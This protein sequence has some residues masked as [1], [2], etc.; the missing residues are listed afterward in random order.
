MEE[1][2]LVRFYNVISKALKIK[3]E[4]LISAIILNSESIFRVNLPGVEMLIPAVM[5]ALDRILPD[6]ELVEFKQHCS[7]TMLRRTAANMRQLL[8]NS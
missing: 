4:R 3:N 8:V 2:Y 1:V 7:I 5:T 6:G